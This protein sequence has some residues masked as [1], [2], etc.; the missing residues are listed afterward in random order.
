MSV[1][2]NKLF[3]DLSLAHVRF[4]FQIL[5]FLQGRL[6]YLSMAGS[7]LPVEVRAHYKSLQGEGVDVLFDRGIRLGDMQR[8][9]CRLFSKRFPLNQVSLVIGDRAKGLVRTRS[10]ESR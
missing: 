6:H 2:T 5:S 1:M 10:Q 4:V 9:L 7:A 8:H 3:V